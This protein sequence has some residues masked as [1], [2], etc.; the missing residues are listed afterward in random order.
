MAH[1]SLPFATSLLCVRLAVWVALALLTACAPGRGRPP[2]LEDAKALQKLL[3]D[4]DMVN[5]LLD[6]FAAGKGKQA[7]KVETITPDQRTKLL[8]LWAPYLDHTRALQ[9]FQ[10]KFLQGWQQAGPPELQTQAL[11]AGM[12]ALAAQ[13]NTNLRFL[14]AVGKRE[15]LRTI[16]NDPEVE[17]GIGAR[18]YDRM[19][20]RMARPQLMF[21]LQLG[22]EALQRRLS[23]I[24]ADKNKENV[25][26]TKIAAKSLLLVQ[27]AQAAFNR[28]AVNVA[29]QAM[30]TVA[31][32]QF[33]ALSGAD[34]RYCRM[35]G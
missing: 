8:S 26:F 24:N 13:V 22:S 12:V 35:A 19:V 27:Q 21:T 4:V 18:E 2:R 17:Y 25:A 15:Q 23:H 29:M 10:I 6:E 11:A 14:R 33:D 31:G 30:A 32:S 3:A 9:S 5:K 1:A 28:Q 20:M 7:A 34:H 16:L